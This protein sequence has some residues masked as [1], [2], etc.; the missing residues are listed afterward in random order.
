MLVV[1][2]LTRP[3]LKLVDFMQSISWRLRDTGSDPVKQSADLDELRGLWAATLARP[4][5]LRGSGNIDEELLQ[6]RRKRRKAMK[7]AREAA[8]QEKQLQLRQSGTQTTL[9][10]ATP[11]GAAES[12]SRPDSRSHGSDSGGSSGDETNSNS[13]TDTKSGEAA[14]S[15]RGSTGAGADSILSPRSAKRKPCG[16]HCCNCTRSVRRFFV[17]TVPRFWLRHLPSVPLHETQLLHSTF[18]GMLTGLQSNHQMLQTANESKRR[19]I[20]YIFHEVR[21]PFNAIVLGVEQL[22][23]DLYT[24]PLRPVE[25]MQDVVNI[26]NEQSKVVAR[27]VSGQRQPVLS[28]V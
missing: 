21:V 14:R 15:K 18:G 19:F 1:Q 12:T 3:L 16:E 17:K 27:I 24:D 23:E 25:E 4:H 2:C 6:L 28:F 26:L 11:A 13:S 10:P 20:R 9:R 7:Q 8:L 22:R 5:L